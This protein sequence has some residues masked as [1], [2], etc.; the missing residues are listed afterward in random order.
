VPLSAAGFFINKNIMKM[1]IIILFAL[2]NLFFNCKQQEEISQS[3]LPDTLK[4]EITIVNDNEPGEK[5]LV[6]GNIIDE[7][8]KPVNGAAIFAYQTDVNGIYSEQGSNNPRIKGYL[9]SG[10]NGEFLIHTIIPGSYPESRNPKHIHFE[11]KKEGFKDS[12]FEIVF[13]GDPYLTDSFIRSDGV[14]LTK[15]NKDNNGNNVCEFEV[16]L[17]K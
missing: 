15:I 13:E 12:F 14:V 17:S 3:T 4:N 16:K 2:S 8:G 7:D 11:I 6:K 10:N 1:Y 5:L 9:K